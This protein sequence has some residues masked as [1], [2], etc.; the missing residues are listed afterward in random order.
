[1]NTLQT[2]TA[3]SDHGT[4]LVPVPPQATPATPAKVKPKAKRAKGNGKAVAKAGK[5][6]QPVDAVTGVYPGLK[7]WPAKAGPV[8]SRVEIIMARAM[9][10]SKIIGTKRELAAAAYLRLCANDYPVVGCI[11]LALQAVFTGSSLNPIM[12]AVNETLVR[13]YGY[14]TP[15][16][17]KAGRHTSYRLQLTGKGKAVIERYATAQG[18]AL[19][20]SPYLPAAK[21]APVA[22]LKAVAETKALAACV[23]A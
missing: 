21:P 7:R 8:P 6:D 20:L 19:D 9:L 2:D 14:V 18:I 13:A 3:T 11:D 23:A 4:A 16:K 5:V 1:M 22:K 17:V 15:I 12:N 10:R